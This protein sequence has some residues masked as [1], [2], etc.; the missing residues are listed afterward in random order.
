MDNRT[1]KYADIFDQFIVDCANSAA[2]DFGYPRPGK[3]FFESLYKDLKPGIRGN[4]GIGIDQGLLL[5]DGRTFKLASLGEKKGPY[6]W[7]SRQRNRQ[8][9]MVNWEYF[10]QVAEFIRLSNIVTTESQKIKFE[11]GLMDL[12]IY[13]QG[14]LYLCCEVKV[15]SRQVSSLLAGVRKYQSGIDFSLPDRGNDSIRKAKYLL[16]HRPTYF[17]IVGIGIRREFYVHFPAKN[18]F[19]LVEDMIPYAQML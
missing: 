16:Q 11:D 4:L 1:R 3:A 10:V 18:Q 19:E 5:S 8:E 15:N 2:D 7:F 6:N 14:E 17:S 13:E 12:A 9:L